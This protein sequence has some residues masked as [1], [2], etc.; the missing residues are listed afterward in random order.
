LVRAGLVVLLVFM[1]VLKVAIVFFQL[2]L[3]LVAV[4]VQPLVVEVQPR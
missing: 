1:A 4:V 3:Q 2:S